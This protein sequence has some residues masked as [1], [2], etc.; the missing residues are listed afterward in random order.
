MSSGYV[1]QSSGQIITGHTIQASD[2]NNEFNQL[3]SAFDATSG[4]IHDGTVGGG[5]P[6]PTGGLSGLTST[7][8]GF[9]SANGG[10]VFTVSSTIGTSQLA[11]SSVTYAKIQNVAAIS[12]LG[13]P[14]G[15]PAAPSEIT[16]TSALGFTG[17]TL[18]VA[19]G[20]ITNA[21]LAGSITATKLVLTDI[22]TLSGLT[23]IGTIGTGVWQATVIAGQ[24]GGTGV[25][26]TGKT[27]TLGGSLTT[28]GAFTTTL[29][30]TANTSVTLP[31]SGTLIT[32]SV[33]TLSLLTSIGTIGT[34]TWQGTI[35]GSTYGGTGVNNGSSTIT[36]AGNV[37]F[38]GAFTF[39]GTLTANTA[40]T[41]PV[42]GKLLAN[43]NN[44]SDV[45]N[46]TTALNNLLPTQTGNSGKFLTTNGT[47]TSW[48]STSGGV[49]S[50]TGDGT[51]LNNSASTGA[52][53]ATLAS[54]A[55]GTVLGNATSTSATPT[56]TSTPQLGASGTL[57]SVTMGNATSG[58]LTLE[59]AT[60]ALGTTTVSIPA[61]T[62]TLVNLTGTQTLANKTLTSPTLVTPALGT[63]ASGNLSNCTNIP[64]PIYTPL[65]I[66]SIALLINNTGSPVS[67]NT[68]HNSNGGVNLAVAKVTTTGAITSSD[69]I[70][71]IWNTFQTLNVGDAGLWQ[72]IS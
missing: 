21:M 3:Q 66:G 4:H 45:S 52:I 25:V 6:I 26:N 44:L 2:F 55:A 68:T 17:T 72:R 70:T 46:I 29:T 63:P 59:P 48:A 11:N 7:S 30:V 54:A 10:G 32:N 14:T 15:S 27:I 69:T 5:A 22:A 60:G 40:I 64:A 38:S 43:S 24:Y 16:L 12:L 65:A 20:G 56:Y 23:T 57:G 36:I 58:L 67:I 19:A 33:T 50:F 42:S 41:F 71:G 47:N 9:I 1:R 28:S 39:A 62:D 34:G 31:I 51:I 61:A 13:N 49:T 37:A 18:T 8:N 35:I 53:T